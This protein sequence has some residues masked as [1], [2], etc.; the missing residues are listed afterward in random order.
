MKLREGE[1]L[2][3]EVG[4]AV[5]LDLLVPEAVRLEQRLGAQYP[6]QRPKETAGPEARRLCRRCDSSS[7]LCA[8]DCATLTICPLI[9]PPGLFAVRTT[10]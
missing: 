1:E 8:A 2:A 9:S 7:Y 6:H 3:A 4:L 10:T 5:D